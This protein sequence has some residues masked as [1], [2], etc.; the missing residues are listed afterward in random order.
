MSSQ[1]PKSGVKLVPKET[2]NVRSILILEDFDRI[3]H[4]F[5]HHFEKR[6]FRVYSAARLQD[7]EA[8]AL[9]ILPQVVI[10]D[11]DLEREDAVEAI[12]TLRELMPGSRIVVYGGI[13]SSEM[14]ARILSAGGS[15]FLPEGYDIERLDKIVG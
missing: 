15:A 3:R 12:K 14:E 7:A 11:Y 4:F 2:K 1:V 5:A 9:T 13:E 10:I 8:V 6:G